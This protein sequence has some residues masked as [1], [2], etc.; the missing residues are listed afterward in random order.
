MR[1]P[2]IRILLQA[3]SVAVQCHAVC[4]S[5]AVGEANFGLLPVAFFLEDLCM[6]CS[7]T[8]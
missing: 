8:F 4:M 1:I 2:S 6:G 7:S 5:G 3:A